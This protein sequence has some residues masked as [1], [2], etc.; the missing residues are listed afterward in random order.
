MKYD[1]LDRS[2]NLIT[3]KLSMEYGPDNREF[4]LHV[5]GKRQIQVE[6]FSK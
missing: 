2:F 6:N 4:K 1:A 3:G 5:H